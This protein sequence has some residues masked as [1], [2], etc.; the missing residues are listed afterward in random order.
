MADR[1]K[2]STDRRLIAAAQVEGVS[3]YAPNGEKIGA[4]ADIY[5]DKASGQVEFVILASGGV[6]GM[7]EKHRPAPWSALTYDEAL[8]GFCLGLHPD[9]LSAAP[10][11][12]ADQLL[13]DDAWAGEVNAYYQ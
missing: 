7:G 12:G 8:K 9:E 13:S 6:L 3:V 10:A 1:M 5:I 11:Y 4:V 2:Q